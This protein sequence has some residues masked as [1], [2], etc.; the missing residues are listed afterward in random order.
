M[1]LNL[2]ASCRSAFYGRQLTDSPRSAV[3]QA[4]KTAVAAAKQ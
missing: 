4:W 3:L 2:I 1:F